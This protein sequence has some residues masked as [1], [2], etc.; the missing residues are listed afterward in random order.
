MKIVTWNMQGD[1]NATYLNQLV[2]KLK[3]NVLCLQE[4]GDLTPLL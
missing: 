3:P 4:T 1:K 2:Q